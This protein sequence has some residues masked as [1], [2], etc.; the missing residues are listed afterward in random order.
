MAELGLGPL[1]RY[2]DQ[3]NAVVWVETSEPCEVQV[4]GSTAPTFTVEGHHYGVVQIRELKPGT[5]YEYEVELDGRQRVAAEEVEAAAQHASAR[6]PRTSSR[7]SRSA[8]AAW[9]CRT[10]RPT[11]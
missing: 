7:G 11:R 8:P 3:T 10:S 4:L 6:T 9:R 2:V 1:L 5:T